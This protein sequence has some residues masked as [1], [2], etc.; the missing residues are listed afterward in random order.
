ME[1]IAVDDIWTTRALD[2]QR[3]F[4]STQQAKQQEHCIAVHVG[5]LVHGVR[6]LCHLLGL[7]VTDM[8]SKA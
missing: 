7:Y 2:N 8:A 6:S 3:P 1:G 4:A 5:L